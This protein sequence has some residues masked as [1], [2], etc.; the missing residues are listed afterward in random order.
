[1][2]I[3]ELINFYPV[4][5][6]DA[7]EHAA[8]NLRDIARPSLNCPVK[9]IVNKIDALFCDL[10][11]HNAL[12]KFEKPDIG[13][14]GESITRTY[15]LF[16]S[17][18][19]YKGSLERIFGFTLKNTSNTAH[20][21]WGLF[22]MR[23][24]LLRSKLAKE[25]HIADIYFDDFFAMNQFLDKLSDKAVAED[26]CFHGHQS[27]VSQPILKNF[28][29][30]SFYQAT[31]EN[32][33]FRNEDEQIICFNTGLIDRM[34][35][36]I[37]IV[38]NIEDIDSPNNL[39]YE[40]YTNPRIM[41]ASDRLFSRYITTPPSPAKFYDDMSELLF[42][43]E[44][45]SAP[46][47]INLND[48]HIFIDNLDRINSSLPKGSKQ[49][50]LNEIIDC[51]GKFESA[52]ACSL[53]LARRNYKLVAPQFWPETGKIQFLMP[54]YLSKICETNE[55]GE[56]T[57][58]LPN[59]A[60]CLEKDN[61]GRYLGTSILTLDM[62]YQN[63]RL[64]A[65][66]DS[67]WLDPHRISSFERTKRSVEVSDS[68]T[69]DEFTYTDTFINRDTNTIK[70]LIGTIGNGEKA[71]LY[72]KN[73]C[74]RTVTQEE[75]KRLTLLCQSKKI[76]VKLISK[77]EKGWNVSIKN[78]TPDFNQ[79]LAESY[80]GEYATLENLEITS[81]GGLRGLIRG[82]NYKASLS[83]NY[84]S[85]LGIQAIE[86]VGKSLG[87]LI[88]RW[89]DNAKAFNVEIVSET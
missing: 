11:Q 18:Y 51:H 26:W 21:Y 79:L 43:C 6:I 73:L 20:Q 55:D 25:I 68:N 32:K 37:Y 35:N 33:T 45:A 75:M 70:G 23:E 12:Y 49:Y 8:S 28:L 67:F 85:N 81:R 57:V 47:G 39:F 50:N 66:P 65:K 60:L 83:P 54:I 30:H 64:I 2:K 24:S 58:V 82:S 53:V 89:D 1:M 38:C 41:T 80:I 63:A 78:M 9:Q 59:V 7:L 13:K 62:A 42:D 27:S 4:E 71:M 34:F 76:A 87:I 22:F 69:I 84:L 86:Y 40:R 74:D 3:F 15:F 56:K 88:T 36:D 44:A 46:H 14:N 52:L 29:E 31:A 72:I 17:G 16:D 5:N 61:N 10:H 48:F 77:S 19:K